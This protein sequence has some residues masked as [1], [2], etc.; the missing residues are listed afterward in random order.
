[1]ISDL[2]NTKG[3][4]GEAERWGGRKGVWEMEEEEG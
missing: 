4:S 3:G 2:D 1:M